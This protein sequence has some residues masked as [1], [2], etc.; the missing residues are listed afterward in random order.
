MVRQ[1]PRATPLAV[2]SGA[3]VA[4]V[5][6]IQEDVFWLWFLILTEVHWA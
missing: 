4:K 3:A 6:L 5:V 1:V 2:F